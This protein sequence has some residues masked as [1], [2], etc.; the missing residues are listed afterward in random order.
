MS[1]PES[2]IHPIT[3]IVDACFRGIDYGEP[4]GVEGEIA[5]RVRSKKAVDPETE[6]EWQLA[7][8]LLTGEAEGT[9]KNV[10]AIMLGRFPRDG[11]ELFFG[12]TLEDNSLSVNGELPEGVDPEDEFLHGLKLTTQSD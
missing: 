7:D 12:F 11:S 10:R 4:D 8:M 9:L 3:N 6:I 5:A 2:Q 1:N